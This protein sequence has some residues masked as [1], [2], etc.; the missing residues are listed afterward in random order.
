M[1]EE[2]VLDFSQSFIEHT[3][4]NVFFT[5]LIHIILRSSGYLNW[6]T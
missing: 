1:E 3:Q 4:L 6:M 2:T 5:I